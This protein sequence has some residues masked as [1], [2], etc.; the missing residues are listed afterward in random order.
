VRS[1]HLGVRDWPRL[2]IYIF[3][4]NLFKYYIVLHEEF[5]GCSR[6]LTGLELFAVEAR[7]AFTAGED[8]VAVAALAGAHPMPAR[9]RIGWRRCMLD[10]IRSMHRPSS[11]GD[12]LR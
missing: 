1:D 2:I 10:G 3:I 11:Y 5:A 12:G 7:A 9:S 8:R 6:S 4:N